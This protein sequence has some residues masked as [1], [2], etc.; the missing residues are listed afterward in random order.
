MCSPSIA[1]GDDSIIPQGRTRRWKDS[2]PPTPSPTFEPYK[3][4]DDVPPQEPISQGTDGS[5]GKGTHKRTI[6]A[7]IPSIERATG[8]THSP[9]VEVTVEAATRKSARTRKSKTQV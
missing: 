5:K 2:K 4:L 1:L 9:S 8:R 6:S 7:A 3:G